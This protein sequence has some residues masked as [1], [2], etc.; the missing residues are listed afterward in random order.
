M[1]KIFPAFFDWSI[2]FP[3]TSPKTIS[4]ENSPIC[5][6]LWSCKFKAN[7]H[8]SHLG[9]ITSALLPH[10]RAHIFPR[11][12]RKRLWGHKEGGA[13]PRSGLCGSQVWGYLVTRKN[14]WESG[15]SKT[16]HVA[17]MLWR[18]PKPTLSCTS[19]QDISWGWAQIEP[20]PGERGTKRETE[21]S[22]W[23]SQ[24]RVNLKHVWPP[25]SK[26]CSLWLVTR[27]QRSALTACDSIQGNASPKSMFLCP[28]PFSL[29]PFSDRVAVHHGCIKPVLST[30]DLSVCTGSHPSEPDS[31]LRKYP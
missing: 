16:W 21:R 11:C 31:T 10:Q 3:S 23:N 29:G 9:F 30:D 24:F 27:Q 1:K 6:R 17:Q 18:G 7:C 28:C 13:V 19:D 26:S 4:E 12:A 5:S 2:D 8:V 15:F 25:L 14:A 22:R 20:F